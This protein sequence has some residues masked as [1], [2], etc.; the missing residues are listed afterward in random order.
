MRKLLAAGLL[1]ALQGCAVIDAYLMTKY[2]PNEY[3]IVTEIRAIARQA[4]DDCS[5]PQ[6][7]KTNA[8]I[9]QTQTNLFKLYSEHIPRNDNGISAAKSLNEMAQGLVDRYKSTEPVSPAFC[10]IKF[11]SIEHSAELIQH[12]LG[13]R[14]R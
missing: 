12:T 6:T 4:K 10:K 3:R 2:D 14:P 13:N 5:N 1:V 9:V 8:I 11:G 7:S